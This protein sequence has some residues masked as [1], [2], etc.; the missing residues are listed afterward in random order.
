MRHIK[1]EGIVLNRRILK[2]V[3]R[4]LT[5]LTEDRGKL[6]LLARSVRSIRSKRAS[7]LDLFCLVRFGY[8]ERGDYKILTHVELVESF[9]QGKK[10]LGD[11]SRLFVIGELVDS[12]VP[13]DDPHPEVY[14]LLLTAL[15][16]L[17][18]FDSPEYL[19]RF[20]TKLLLLLGYGDQRGDLDAYIE[21]LLARPLHAKI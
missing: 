6:T 5:I 4:F 15:T 17:T 20:K 9:R 16:H 3:D 2:D 13:E 14:N 11:I 7:S 19:D 12:L 21:T 18:R 8:I 1:S 10:K